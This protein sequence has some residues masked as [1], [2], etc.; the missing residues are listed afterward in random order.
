MPQI[1]AFDPRIV[2]H[3]F[4]PFDLDLNAHFDFESEN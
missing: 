4:D 3:D 1:L 2:Q